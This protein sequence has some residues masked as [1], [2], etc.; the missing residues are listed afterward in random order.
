M[1]EIDESK[2]GWRWVVWSEL[3]KKKRDEF[4]LIPIRFY[5]VSNSCLLKRD[6][7]FGFGIGIGIGI[8]HV[9]WWW[10]WWW[11]ERKCLVGACVDPWDSCI[12]KIYVH[13]YNYYEQ[14]LHSWFC[15]KLFVSFNS[16]YTLKCIML[17]FWERK[18]IFLDLLWNCSS[19]Y[20]YC[21]DNWSF[22]E[23]PLK[24]I[25]HAQLPFIFPLPTPPP[26]NSAFL[27]HLMGEKGKKKLK[28][29]LLSK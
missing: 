22:Q 21:V 2:R 20:V 11:W 12:S 23:K 8:G 3:T 7:G 29:R 9:W 5:L 14:G 26:N 15:I 13:K 24:E 18:M 10:W 27:L 19:S 1:N 28:F 16:I 25:L 4:D 6:I 17:L